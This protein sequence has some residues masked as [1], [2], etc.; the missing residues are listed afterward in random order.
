MKYYVLMSKYWTACTTEELIH[1]YNAIQWGLRE[2]VHCRIRIFDGVLCVIP[3][4]SSTKYF[5][6]QIEPG[7][8]EAASSIRNILAHRGVYDIP[9]VSLTYM[10]SEEADIRHLGWETYKIVKRMGCD[11]ADR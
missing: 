10:S 9:H 3:T 11:Y 2:R 4:I 6:A 1:H 8:R 5:H 7:M